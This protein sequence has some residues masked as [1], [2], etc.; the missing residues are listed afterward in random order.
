MPSFS[1]IG[2]VPR[3]SLNALSKGRDNNLNLLRFLAAGLVIYA[4]SFGITGNIAREPFFAAFG[5]GIGDIAVDVFFVVSGFL[6]AKSFLAK[7]L[8]VFLWAR[9]MRIYP[10]L[11]VSSLLFVVVAQC[12]T[13]VATICLLILLY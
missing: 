10:A 1:F 11:W 8:H 6:I 13:V 3:A 5:I 2:L 12:Y 7:P 4:H 9:A